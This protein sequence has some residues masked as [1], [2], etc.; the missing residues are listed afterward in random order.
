MKILIV[1][2][3][4]SGKFSP[5]IVEQVAA[6]GRLGVEFEYFGIEGKGLRGYLKN[7]NSLKKKVEDFRP[8]LVHAHYGLSGLLAVMQRKRPV[9]VTYHGSDIHEGGITR[10]LSKMAM[11]F[12]KYNIFVTS[13]LQRLSGQSKRAAVIECGVDDDVFR[14]VDKGK[15]RESLGWSSSRRYVVFA[16]AFDRDVKNPSLAKRAVSELKDC[17]LIEL[18]GYTRDQVNLLFNAADCLLMT[19]RNEGSPQVIKE[20]MMCGLPIVSVDVGDVKDVIGATQGC[21]ITSY[22][23]S[24][25]AEAIEEVTQLNVRTDGRKRIYE[26]G[27]TNDEVAKKVRKVYSEVL[28]NK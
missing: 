18:K 27:L 24:E 17:E 1:A 8:D 16:G 14:P 7:L 11:R 21:R 4:N 28:G 5:F 22:S 6:L 25:I 26:L 3:H 2:S 12:A 10:M 13:R 23:P 20:A 19:S 9:V 15:A